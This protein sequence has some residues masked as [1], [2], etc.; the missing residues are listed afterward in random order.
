MA[1]NS[2]EVGG[3]EKVVVSLLK[4]LPKDRFDPYLIC[5]SGKGQLFSELDLPEENCLIL[6][7]KHP[8]GKSLAEKFPLG[9]VLR[10]RDFLKQNRIDVLHLHN[11]GPLLYAGTAA[12]MCRNR[13]AVL[14]TEHNQ[15][16]R[17][18]AAARKRFRVYVRA[19]DRIIAVSH[20]LKRTLVEEVGVTRPVDVIH[21]GIDGGRFDGVTG[22]AVRCELGIPADAFVIGTAVVLGEQKGINFLLDAAK[23]AL[24]KHPDIRFLIAG[25]GYMRQEFERHASD[26][27]V[28][29]P[30]R[31]LG[32]RS[33][34]PQ[35][36]AAFD[37]YALTSLW[38][39][40]PLA[41]L[42]ALALGKP[43]VA[44]TVGGN[45][46]VVQDQVNGFLIPPRDPIAAADAFIKLFE[47]AALRA[48]MSRANKERFR[49]EF[50]LGSMLQAH[51]RAYEEARVSST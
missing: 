13:P 7:K 29:G 33:D 16:Y 38:E 43:I 50:S 28:M 11:Q 2:L 30:V 9:M 14:Y 10:I 22:D 42:E 20:D 5:L 23:I 4:G 39:G 24:H 49:T 37:A 8:P 32:Y 26:I 3:L 51:V 48:E 1:V 15:I 35:V 34:V 41:L 45:P 18:G 40:L 36:L 6:H 19:A 21:N 44:T 25:D 27:G 46:E 17:A 31:F 12:R 47:D